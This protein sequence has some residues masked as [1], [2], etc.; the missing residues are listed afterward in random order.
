MN[1]LGDKPSSKVLRPPGGGSNN[2]FGVAEETT[3]GKKN[4][5][6]TYQSSV[7]SSD[8]EPEKPK[9]AGPGRMA[10]NIFG[11]DNNDNSVTTP[12]KVSKTHQSSLFQDPEPASGNKKVTVPPRQ[13]P[14][15]GGV[16]GEAKDTPVAP[17]SS[18]IKNGNKQESKVQKAPVVSGTQKDLNPHLGPIINTSGI[19]CAQPPGGKSSF[20][21]G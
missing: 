16:L 1:Y 19:R 21:L 12:K 13:D 15:T 2:I 17:V 3:A 6:P 5:K 10:S 14:I 7:F 9:S 4:S 18:E 8:P 11:T 20:S